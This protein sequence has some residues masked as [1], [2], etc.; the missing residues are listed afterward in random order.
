M[1]GK[2]TLLPTLDGSLTY[3]NLD[4]QQ[5]YHSMNGALQEAHHVFL[6]NGLLNFQQLY[7]AK[8]INILEIG[9]GSG[10][11]FLVSADYC[12]ANNIYLN[13]T[14]IE[15]YPLERTLLIDSHY[16]KWVNHQKLWNSYLYAY[17]DLFKSG[18]MMNLSSNVNLRLMHQELERFQTAEYA[19]II[20][21][22]AF[23][24]GTHPEIWEK[25]SIVHALSF[26]KPQGHFITYSITGNLK[27]ILRSIGFTIEK[28][29]G[30]AGKREM[31]RAYKKPVK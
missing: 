8:E 18:T 11:N 24:P 29:K 4:I 9:F 30:A 2:I 28:P 20:Y 10:L 7:H 15:P 17:N 16:N 23:A 21:F 13:Y 22:D 25:Q 3:F 19:D 12:E 27:R 31:L 14:G 5:S 1:E 26:L 6:E